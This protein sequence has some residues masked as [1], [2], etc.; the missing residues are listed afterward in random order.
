MRSANLQFYNG[1]L[2]FMQL[3]M[4][5]TTRGGF[6]QVIDSRDVVIF[7]SKCVADALFLADACNACRHV[8]TTA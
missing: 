2:M 4:R 7:E 8:I 5:V 1:R 3:P 6:S